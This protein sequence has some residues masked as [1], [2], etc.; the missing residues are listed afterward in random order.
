MAYAIAL[1]LDDTLANEVRQLWHELEAAGVGKTPGQF[2]ELP[3]I[4]LS[5]HPDGDC[6]SLVKLIDSISIA[7]LRTQLVPFG[8]FLGEKHVL[9]YTAV[10]SEELLQAHAQHYD[11]LKREK[12]EFDPL[13]SPGKIVFHCTMAVDIE[14]E[15][16]H[17]GINIC[18]RHKD[19]LDGSVEGIELVEFFLVKV[20]HRKTLVAKRREVTTPPT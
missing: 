18:L 9:Y 11:V 13:Y 6:E 2:A 14:D 4:T 16:L 7:D 17:D 19:V 3:H 5:L 8:T 1:A 20:I 15:R 10:L 12:I